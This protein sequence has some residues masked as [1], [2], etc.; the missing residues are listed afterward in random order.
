MY[1]GVLAAALGGL[2]IYQ[3]W[4]ALFVI[5]T[6]LSLLLRARHEEQALAAEFGEQWKEYCRLVPGWM[7]RFLRRH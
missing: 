6:F 4:T 1:L 3:T 5:A 2:L 7:P